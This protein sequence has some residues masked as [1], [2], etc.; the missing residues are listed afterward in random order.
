MAIA[1]LP[2]LF[3]Y[4]FWTVYRSN[5]HE[6]NSRNNFNWK[7]Y[8]AVL[9]PVFAFAL[10]IYYPLIT[11]KTY[12]NLNIDWVKKANLLSIPRSITA[13][14][15]GIKSKTAGNDE[16]MHVNFIV[17]ET[18]LGG[19]IFVL[20]LSGA[21]AV[22]I[23]KRK[24]QK[25]LADFG[26]VVLMTFLPMLTLIVYVI[27]RNHNIYV[28]RYLYP[29]SI[30][31]VISLA[32]ILT[33]LLNFEVAGILLFFYVYTLLHTA[34]AGY[35][36]GMKI[37]AKDFKNSPIEI[38]FTSPIDFTVGKYYLN[39]GMTRLFVPKEPANQSYFSWP[40]IGDVFP[41]NMGEAI[42]ISP[43]PGRM[44]SDFIRP[45]DNFQYGNYQIWIKK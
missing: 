20:F 37:L 8:L 10:F 29:A 41:R 39:N 25:T 1:F 12:G 16:L 30:F 28:E 34:P 3:L 17:H 44:T 38:V 26:F 2:P 18:F 45:L 33:S 11:N 24:D 31:F 15:Y 19:A 14:S 32:Y 13:Y 5:L 43:D 22:F 42:F 21:I 35:Y 27:L 36:T 6:A 7:K 40:F 9:L 23:K 4:Y